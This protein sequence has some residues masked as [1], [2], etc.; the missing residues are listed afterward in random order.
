MFLKGFNLVFHSE[1]KKLKENSEILEKL[2]Q[3]S[4]K[5]WNFFNSDF[6]STWGAYYA[7][8]G[9]WKYMVKFPVFC[10][11]SGEHIF[12]HSSTYLKNS[13]FI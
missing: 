13:S 3:N 5:K 4:S 7:E 10:S 9:K 2:M 1:Y 6:K 12:N 11:L 8:Y